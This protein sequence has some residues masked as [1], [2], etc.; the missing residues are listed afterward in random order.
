MPTALVLRFVA[1]ENLDGFAA[2]F[3]S[4]AFTVKTYDVWHPHAAEWAESADI[5]VV[6]GGPVGAG[7]IEDYPYLSDLI[8]TLR[9]R[10]EIGLPT[11]G[12]GLGSQLMAQALG[13]E[14]H[15][16]DEPEI[17]IQPLVLTAEGHGSA[18]ECFA[19][20]PL[21]WHWHQDYFDLPAGTQCL[22]R[23]AQT[24]VQAFSHGPNILACQFH[25]EFSGE[26]EAWLVG[27]SVELHQVGI[28]I[29][30][31]RHA[32]EAYREEFHRKAAQV[33]KRW[34]QGLALGA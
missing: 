15:R 27:H 19:D 7:D 22:A 20:E 32:V 10:L 1:F 2:T 21:A 26:V 3:L 16:A 31:L 12:I 14:I 30:E 23:S 4:N 8:L 18:L 6:M 29:S 25:P 34:L 24:K 13:A 33:A 5:V 11:L 17:G 28:D 9:D